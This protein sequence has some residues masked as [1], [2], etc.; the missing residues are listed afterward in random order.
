MG[1]VDYKW[2]VYELLTPDG[3]VFYVGKGSGKRIDAH[4][5]E[6]LKGV[7]SKKCNKI[8]S[9]PYIIKQKVALFFNEQDAYDF[10]TDRISHYGLNNLTNIMRGGQ[11]AFERRVK[12]LKIKQSRLKQDN[13]PNWIRITSNMELLKDWIKITDYGNYLVKPEK[14]GIKLKDCIS[15]MATTI[16]ND[17]FPKLIKSIILSENKNKFY[18]KINNYGVDIWRLEKIAV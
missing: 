14:T 10:E 2:Y 15:E 13:I 17:V 1:E 6:A 4:E 3:D 12:K 5:K 11:I 7:C 16:Y 8:R 18:E 9:L